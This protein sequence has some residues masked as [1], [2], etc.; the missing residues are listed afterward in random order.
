MNGPWFVYLVRFIDAGKAKYYAAFTNHPSVQIACHLHGQGPKCLQEAESIEDGKVVFKHA[1]FTIARAMQ[2][3][4]RALSN[5]TKTE[6]FEG[7]A[8]PSLFKELLGKVEAIL[9]ARG[10]QK[11]MPARKAPTEP[12]IKLVHETM[13]LDGTIIETRQE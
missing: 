4:V 12:E 7:I 11:P 8:P 13:N 5:A 10:K 1:D 2:E 6:L 3:Q 9:K